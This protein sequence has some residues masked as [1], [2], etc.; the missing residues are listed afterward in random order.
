MFRSGTH[1]VARDRVS[2]VELWRYDWQPQ[3]GSPE[4]ELYELFL[5]PRDWL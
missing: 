2:G 3:A 1:L 5:Q 4:A